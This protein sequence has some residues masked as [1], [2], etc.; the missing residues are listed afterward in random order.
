MTSTYRTDATGGLP[1]RQKRNGRR[2]IAQLLVCSGLL[3]PQMLPVAYAGTVAWQE[4]I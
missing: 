2:L 3:V 4:G 1:S